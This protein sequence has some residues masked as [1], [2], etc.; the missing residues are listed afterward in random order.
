MR[1]ILVALAF[2]GAHQAS[3]ASIYK[4]S[5]GT[6]VNQYVTNGV[7]IGGEAGSGFTLLGVRRANSSKAALERVILDIGDRE[8]QPLLNKVGYFHVSIE[9]NPSRVIIDLSQTSRSKISELELAK[10]FA[11]SP[12]VTKAELMMEEEDNSAKIVLNTKVPVAAEVFRMPSAKKAS[13][14]VIDL[15]KAKL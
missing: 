7:V 6:K 15:K 13:R 4:K 12:F 1:T 2:I 5:L 8:G 14:I 9:K 10:I 3:A 11:K